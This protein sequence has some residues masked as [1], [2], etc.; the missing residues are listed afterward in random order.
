MRTF[1]K[2]DL[3]LVFS[4]KGIKLSIYWDGNPRLCSYIF[5][6][7]GIE[8]MRGADFKPSPLHNIDD[9]LT[10]IECLGFMV[11]ARGD[12]DDEYFKNHT[13]QHLAWLETPQRDEINHYISDYEC[14]TAGDKL[15]EEYKQ[16]WEFFTTHIEAYPE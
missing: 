13:P 8:L 10:V 15:Q 1:D 5:E 7:D 9:I 14:A 2:D 3:M 6:K 11:V 16:A 12:T 4:Y